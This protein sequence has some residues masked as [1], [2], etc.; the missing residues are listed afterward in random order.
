MSRVTTSLKISE[1]KVL[2]ALQDQKEYTF[3]ELKGN[4]N[5]SYDSLS[6]A[7]K[8]LQRTRMIKRSINSRK[9]SAAT[10][11]IR[12]LKKKDLANGIIGSGSI[13]EETSISPP[14]SAIVA[15]DDKEAQQIYGPGTPDIAK[16]CFKQFLIDT[17]KARLEIHQA[18]DPRSLLPATGRVIYTA[19][20]DWGQVRPWL[21]SAEGKEYLKKTLEEMEDASRGE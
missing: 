5:L 18:G 21:D 8:S 2:H 6:K 1:E 3:T 7:L 16:A 12:Y 10:E 4:T 14:V 9:Y 19:A 20:I 11:G 15:V 13:S 17:L